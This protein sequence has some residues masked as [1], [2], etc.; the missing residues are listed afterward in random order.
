MPIVNRALSSDKCRELSSSTLRWKVYLVK[1]IL[2]LT[3][4]NN[5]P[6][7]L[8]RAIAAI[9]AIIELR[10]DGRFM[11]SGSH[12]G[13]SFFLR[14]LCYLCPASSVWPFNHYLFSG[15]IWNPKP[16][17]WLIHRYVCLFIAYV[18]DFPYGMCLAYFAEHPLKEKAAGRPVVMLPTILYSNDTSGY[19]S[20]KMELFSG[21]IWN[22]KPFTWLIHRYVCL[23]IAYV[24]DIPYGIFI[25]VF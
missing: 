14:R 2:Y 16:F 18:M 17:T 9:T 15:G 11:L 21:G 3:L 5:R 22:P 25:A 13:L 1:K 6:G 12:K 10:V 23:F 24:I 19:R 8:I 20:K 4:V 7:V